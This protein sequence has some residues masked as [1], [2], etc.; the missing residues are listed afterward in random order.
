MKNYFVMLGS[1]SI[2]IGCT[3][4]L[5]SPTEVVNIPTS[6]SKTWEIRAIDESGMFLDTIVLYVNNTKVAAGKL[7]PIEHSAELAGS[8]EQHAV[9]GHCT[10]INTPRKSLATWGGYQCTVYVNGAKVTTLI[11]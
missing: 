5:Q 1:V 2:L 3:T 10:I 8:F 7:N 11:F 9:L 4:V 6:H